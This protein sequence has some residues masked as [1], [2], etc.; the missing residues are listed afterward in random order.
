MVLEQLDNHMEKN[1]LLPMVCT[2]INS[3]LIIGLSATVETKK[4][5]ESRQNAL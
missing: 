4:F 2:K 3:R 5:L 1:D